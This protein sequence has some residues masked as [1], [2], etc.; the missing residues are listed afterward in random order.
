MWK[1]SKPHTRPKE[2][3]ENIPRTNVWLTLF[4]SLTCRKA[5]LLLTLTEIRIGG[6]G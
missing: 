5:S 3:R 2:M 4:L 1:D 6:K